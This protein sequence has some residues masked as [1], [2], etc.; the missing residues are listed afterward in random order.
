MAMKSAAW[1]IG[2]QEEAAGRTLKG[3]EGEEGEDGGAGSMV[4]ARWQ[5]VT[6][7]R[8]LLPGPGNGGEKSPEISIESERKGR[9]RIAG[10][11]AKIA[12]ADGDPASGGNRGGWGENPTARGEAR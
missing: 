6:G 8:V 12:G 10:V 9:K 7:R 5:L 2:D 4:E 11:V 3:P 1:R